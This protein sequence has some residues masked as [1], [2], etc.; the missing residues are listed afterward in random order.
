MYLRDFFQVS[1]EDEGPTSMIILG[2]GLIAICLGGAVGYIAVLRGRPF[3]PWLLYGT[4]LGPIALPHALLTSSRNE[5]EAQ[6]WSPIRYGL[7]SGHRTCPYC[8]AVV[9]ED[10]I[11]CR[12]CRRPFYGP[13]SEGTGEDESEDEATEEPFAFE[14]LEAAIARRSAAAHGRRG[15][16][17]EPPP[18]DAA[19][20]PRRRAP[21]P[22]QAPAARR[23]EPDDRGGTPSHEA[24]GVG[25]RADEAPSARQRDTRRSAA[26]RTAARPSRS[27]PMPERQPD[28]GDGRGDRTGD[29]PPGADRP[30]AVP[31][32]ETARP[33]AQRA[34]QPA[35]QESEPPRAPEIEEPAAKQPDT[36]AHDRDVDAESGAARGPRSQPVSAPSRA[37]PANDPAAPAT[38]RDPTPPREATSAPES[39]ETR[40][41]GTTSHQETTARQEAAASRPAGA[42]AHHRWRDAAA[43]RNNESRPLRASDRPSP[44]PTPQDDLW[45]TWR[46]GAPR[47]GAERTKRATQAAAAVLCV[48]A[49]GGLAWWYGPTAMQ[50]VAMAPS[51]FGGDDASTDLDGRAV[52]VPER[53]LAAPAPN[54]DGGGTLVPEGA[55]RPG[56]ELATSRPAPDSVPSG[57]TGGSGGGDAPADKPAEVPSQPP[58]ETAE[59]PAPTGSAA[60]PGDTASDG[61]ADQGAPAP[62]TA[63]TSGTPAPNAG[64]SQ[65]ASRSRD[66]SVSAGGGPTRLER[67]DEAVEAPTS[68]NEAPAQRQP[69]DDLVKAVTA[70]L[71]EHTGRRNA[72]TSATSGPEGRATP[73]AV[74]VTATGD[75]VA[76]VQQ[77]LRARGFAP[78]PIDGRA[79]PQTREAIRKYQ[80]RMGMRTTGEI[81]KAMLISLG[82]L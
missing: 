29:A 13:G 63:S 24:A 6:A 12:R 14:A 52:E 45:G 9:H 37:A 23:E 41:T 58:M 79:G 72:S 66:A 46:G 34:E 77:L 3:V 28:A 18:Q 73:A 11:A 60:A 38:N 81:D 62:E 15:G 65:T 17:R 31:D 33:A 55:S 56:D 71:A 43:A 4:F 25:G 8:D 36:P 59:V 69:V 44:G 78:G 67:R 21:S 32:R 74:R 26:A 20:R 16:R 1:T 51:L 80:Q 53:E 47:G 7:P 75:L 22:E 42:R 50:Q 82:I 49:V 61:G 54:G 19:E 30:A 68:A 35:N 10:A 48:I 39:H 27:A 5:M 64:S 76:R 57:D 2:I 70:A 40:A